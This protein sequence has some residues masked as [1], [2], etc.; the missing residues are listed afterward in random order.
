MIR[1]TAL[2]CTDTGPTSATLP[3]LVLLHG[4][5]F[6]G[7]LWRRQVEALQDLYRVIV[8]DL[9]SFGRSVGNDPFTIESQADEVHGL[10]MDRDALPCVLCGLSMGGYVALAYAR[11]YPA[12]LRGLILMDTKSAADTSEAK[13]QRQKMID[14]AN[15]SGSLAVAD[16]M[17]PKLLC[18][19]TLTGYPEIA[20]EIQSMAGE[21]P[22]LTLAHALAAMRDR[23]DL[24][25]YLPSIAEPTLILVGAEDAITPPAL[26][27]EM[28]R[29]IPNSTLEVITGSGHVTAME[30]P[31]QVNVA[32]RNF[33]GGF[34]S[35][36]V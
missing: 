26:S 32:I 28:H 19:E 27:Q 8:P 11:K 9:R 29:A 23:P 1:K 17:M 16:A 31:D 6:N 15:T 2:F 7:R 12:T 36:S 22:P 13:L 35:Q 20:K 21:N 25:D 14:L 3:P 33:M 5:P 30:R 24:S 34:G 18:E 10:L 4:F